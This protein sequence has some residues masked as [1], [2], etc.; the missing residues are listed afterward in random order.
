MM[1][2]KSGRF[3]EFLGCVKYPECKTIMNLDKDGNVLP[4]KPPPEPTGVKC[5]KCKTG[6]FV[7]RQSK[8]GPFMGCNKF[9]RCRTIVSAKLVEKLL[10]L[11]EEGKW[12]PKNPDDVDEI[13]ER[14][15]TAKK[16]TAKKKVAKKK[17]AK[18]KTAK[19]KAAK[20]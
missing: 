4:P 1:M 8:R 19:K 12:P 6:E 18:K 2:H 16:K 10:G 17:V 9:P 3:G 14:K 13:L 20:D 11:Q 5:H 7:I 15:K